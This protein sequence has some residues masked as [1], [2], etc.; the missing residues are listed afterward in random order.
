MPG[1]KTMSEKEQQ[2]K[3]EEKDPIFEQYRKVMKAL[4][5]PILLYSNI[6]IPYNTQP[7][8]PQHFCQHCKTKL[9]LQ[10]QITE[11]MLLLSPKLVNMDW[12]SLFV[13]TCSNSCPKSLEQCVVIQY[14]TDAIKEQEIGALKK[15][16][17]NRKRKEKNR[18]KKEKSL[19]KEKVEIEEEGE[20][21]LDEEGDW[22]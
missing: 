11:K 20:G 8:N 3:K 17:K 12:G 4:E 7:I 1:L 9:S 19:Q 13:F 6:P 2:T 5:G 16:Q 10:L 18:E 22:D 21:R 15:R 14:E